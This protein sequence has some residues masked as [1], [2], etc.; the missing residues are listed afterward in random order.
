MTSFDR[1]T[2]ARAAAVDRIVQSLQEQGFVGLVGEADVG[3]TALLAAA[4][5]RLRQSAW[6]VV[7][8]DL[9]GAWSPNRLAWRWARELVR[10][11]TG[12]TVLSH[13]DALDPGMWPEATRKALLHLPEQVGYEVATLA[14][15][16][17]PARGVGRS[18]ALDALISATLNLANDTALILVIDHLETPKA[19][20][21]SSPD[22]S[23]LLWR[24]RSRGQYLRNLHVAVCTRPPAQDIASGPQAAYHMDGRWLTLDVPSVANFSEATEWDESIVNIIVNRTGGHPRATMEVLDEL[25]RQIPAKRSVIDATVGRIAERHIDNARRCLQHARSIHRLGGHLFLA[26]AQSRGPYEA[27]P[28]IESSEVSQAMTRLHLNGLVR[29]MGTREWAPADPRVQW[30]LG[31]ARHFQISAGDERSRLPS[32]GASASNDEDLAHSALLALPPR[33]REVCRRIVRGESTDEIAHALSLSPHTVRHY[34]RTIYT[35]FGVKN[36][37]ELYAAVSRAD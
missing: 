1:L 5:D 4:V 22:A 32:R 26:V 34:L 8:L 24:L 25:P 21:L 20:G 23:E 31:G 30:V 27:T 19:A 18:S 29:R 15:A 28:E 35:E 11:V 6:T 2:Q 10:A 3:K 12:P 37:A 9:D 7:H 36:R 14:E 13:V 17:Q 16:R 33:A